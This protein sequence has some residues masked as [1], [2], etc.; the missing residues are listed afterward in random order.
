MINQKTLTNR[1]ED[2]MYNDDYM[3]NRMT[4]W[5]FSGGNSHLWEL[6]G[7]EFLDINAGWYE[8]P[9]DDIKKDDDEG[10]GN[11]KLVN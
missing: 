5:M 1:G 6:G 7:H 9:Y 8:E 2:D 4:N 3:Y 10:R 11:T